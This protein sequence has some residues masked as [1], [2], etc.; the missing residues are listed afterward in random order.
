MRYINPY[1]NVPYLG[2]DEEGNSTRNWAKFRFIGS[3]ERRRIKRMVRKQ[4]NKMLGRSVHTSEL[5]T[6]I[7][8]KR[9]TH[10]ESIREGSTDT[11]AAIAEAAE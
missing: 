5:L 6:I 7:K 9:I 1:I 10:A 2:M 11:A 4:M 8:A 3:V